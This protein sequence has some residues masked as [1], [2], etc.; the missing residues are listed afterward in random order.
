M[1]TFENNVDFEYS[2]TN[3]NQSLKNIGYP[4]WNLSLSTESGPPRN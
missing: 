1:R 3:L 4:N 2:E